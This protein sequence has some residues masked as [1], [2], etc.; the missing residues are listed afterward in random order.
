MYKLIVLILDKLTNNKLIVLNVKKTREML[1]GFR[2]APAVIPDFFID[3][4]KFERVAQ[5]KYLGTVLDN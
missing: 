4:V 5:C 1:T 3:G 2:K